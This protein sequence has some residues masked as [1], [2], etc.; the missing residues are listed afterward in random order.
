MKLSQRL[1]VIEPSMT[2]AVT[3][4]AAALKAQGIDVISFGAGEPDFDTPTHIKDAAKAALDRGATKYTAVEGTPELRKAVAEWFNRDHGLDVTPKEVM[5]N[6]GAKQSIYNALHAVLN[7]G[8]EVILPAP[9]WVSYSEI[10]RLAGGV[11]VPVVAT[12]A[13]G[14]V[15][16][17]DKVAAAI[18]PKTRMIM[19]N[20]PSNPTGAVYGEAILRDIAALAV[21]HDFWILTDDIYRYLCYGDAKFVQPATFGPEV[22]KR[23]IIVDGVS[24]AYAMTGWRIGFTCAPVEVITAMGV[25][26]GQSTSNPAT[27]SQ[28]AA[29]AALTGPQEEV[30]RMRA[31]FD[32]RRK[33]MVERLRAIPGVKCTEPQGAF[34]AFPDVSSFV[35]KKTPDGKVLKDDLAIAEYLITEGKIAVVPGSAFYGPGYV[36]L[37]YACSLD[38]I[39]KGLAR[40][41]DAL[42]KLG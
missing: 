31:E 5:V 35:G 42:G 24:K 6:V 13:D 29:L 26:Q 8:D 39:E 18:T 7:E 9:Y 41:K 2:L 20:S 17:A 36:R 3:A 30:G 23:T 12:A 27:V 34:Y 10:V 14:F 25:L 22:R 32:K 38:N 19:L 21:K 33:V 1:S 40:M 37:S 11:P 4:K 28:A 16:R 15:V